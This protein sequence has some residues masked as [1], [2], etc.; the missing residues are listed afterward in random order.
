VEKF[1]DRF[2]RVSGASWDASGGK[3]VEH[4]GDLGRVSPFHGR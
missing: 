1:W 4:T 2:G 3:E